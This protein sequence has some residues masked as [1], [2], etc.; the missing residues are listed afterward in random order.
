MSG[1]QD[2]LDKGRA[3]ADEPSLVS[4]LSAEA[5]REAKGLS[6]PFSAAESAKRGSVPPPPPPGAT[7]AAP[8]KQPAAP[9]GVATPE[10]APNA[11]A[12]NESG[13]KID[14]G[15]DKESAKESSPE[16]EKPAAAPALGAQESA[17]ASSD[18]ED[19]QE[20]DDLDELE[21]DE[22][23]VAEIRGSLPPELPPMDP[24]ASAANKGANKPPSAKPAPPPNLPET[25]KLPWFEEFF[26]DDYLRTVLPPTPREIAVECD[27]IAETLG[28]EAGT[29]LLDI[30]CGLGLHAIDLAERGVLVVGL[31]LSLP[32]LSRAADEAQDRGLRINFLHG[33]MRDMTFEGAFDAALSWGTSF[34]YFDD[35]SNYKVLLRMREALRPGGKLLLDVVNRDFVTRSQPN[36]VWFEGDG[37]VCMEESKVNHINSRLEVKRTVMLDDGRQRDASYSIR[38]YALHE[39]GQLLSK[40]GFRVLSVSGMRATPGV[41]FG[42]DSPRMMILAERKES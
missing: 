26:S 30:G 40:A 8:A 9:E 36:S 4:E 3:G 12:A 11:S 10:A 18:D 20:L 38:I 23:E 13:P 19:T 27:F 17:A 39:L 34:G 7:S 2:E 6:D 16:G 21:V 31:D 15:T 24:P 28:L 29:T 32:M 41:F 5:E 37:C 14:K 22:L 42:A 1:A 33:D 35:E 25:R